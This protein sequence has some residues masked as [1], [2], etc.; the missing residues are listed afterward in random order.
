MGI[1][2]AVGL[3]LIAVALFWAAKKGWIE[4]SALRLWV[5]VAT[6]VA[7]LAAVAVLVIPAPMPREPAPTASPEIAGLTVVPVSADTSPP[8]SVTT[9]I[10]TAVP[11]ATAT[12]TRLPNPTKTPLPTQ[13]PSTE[14]PPTRSAPTRPSST[15]SPQPTAASQVPS[16][17]TGQVIFLGNQD[18]TNL[19]A[20]ELDSVSLHPTR[21]GLGANG[22]PGIEMDAFSVSRYR[23][24][25]SNGQPIA[26]YSLGSCPIS[27]LNIPSQ[28]G[29]AW[30][31][32]T[33]DEI[34]LRYGSDFDSAPVIH[35]GRITWMG[36][37]P[38]LS[39]LYF[40]AEESSDPRGDYSG[41]LYQVSSSGEVT[42]IHHDGSLG[43]SQCG[44]SHPLDSVV[45][46]PDAS[47]LAFAFQ[48]CDAHFRDLR[49]GRSSST[50][51]GHGLNGHGFGLV[52]GG[53]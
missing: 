16:L 29:L 45:L 38:D 19:Y 14:S 9:V 12:P 2:A 23:Y 50:D 27:R 30:T 46:S 40:V 43:I 42:I 49:T 28:C 53:L 39:T 8:V 11:L 34:Q 13:T 51:I 5:D 17:G 18:H 37:T 44:Q 35:T 33:D 22:C 24:C 25:Y 32:G 20:F 26:V 21:V 41:T 1:I 7:F 3:I 10:L 47:F 15:S 52:L 6:I 48:D 31:T 36:W 4:S